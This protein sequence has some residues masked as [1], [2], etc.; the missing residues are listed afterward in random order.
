MKQLTDETFGE[1]EKAPLALVMFSAPWAGPC[2]LVRP[3]F[4]A[5]AAR[6]GNQMVFGEFNLD[7]NPGVP[8]RFG[9]RAIPLFLLMRNGVPVTIKVGAVEED[10]LTQLCS[11]AIEEDA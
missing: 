6:Y 1:A 10:V 8:E 7:D 9:V 11:A 5:T 3:A 2:N 4:E